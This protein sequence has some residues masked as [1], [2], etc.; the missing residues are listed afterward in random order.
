MQTQDWLRFR[1][2]LAIAREPLA[3]GQIRVTVQHQDRTWTGEG[4]PVV[5]GVLLQAIR[6]EFVSGRLAS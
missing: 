6:G 2:T 3:D 5:E 1:A 4:P